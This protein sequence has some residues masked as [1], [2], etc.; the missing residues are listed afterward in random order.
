MSFVQT[1]FQAFPG[2][3]YQIV[4]HLV[5]LEGDL[6]AH[7]VSCLTVLEA[8]RWSVFTFEGESGSLEDS[9]CLA[10]SLNSFGHVSG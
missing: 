5:T 7:Q 1:L 4:S 9:L 10:K 8:N 3:F 6:E 2:I